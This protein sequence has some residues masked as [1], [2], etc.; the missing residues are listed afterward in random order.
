MTFS[1]S[2]LSR[3]LSLFPGR[4]AERDPRFQ[5]VLEQLP[6]AAFFVAPR[7]G[8]F[9]A[10]NGKA[11]ALT[12]WTRD[13]LMR[14]SLAEIIVAPPSE[15]ALEQFYTLE[16]GNVRHLSAIPLRTRSG[17]L[18]L[19]DLRLSALDDPE[20]GETLVLVLATPVEERLAHQKSKAQQERVLETMDQL[21]T[22]FAAPTEGSLELVVQLI[23]EMLSADAAGLYRVRSNTPGLHLG[24]SDGVPP[25][26]PPTIAPDQSA[27]LT[28]PLT[29]SS[30]QRTEAFLYQSARLA[31]WSQF[32]A[33]PIG[34]APFVIGS[35]FVAYRASN[36]ASA[37]TPALLAVAARHVHHLIIQITRE[38]NHLNAQELALRL[39]SRLAAINA[40]IEEGVVLIN[41]AGMIDEFNPAAARMFGYRS[42]EVTG[43]PCDEVLVAEGQLTEAIRRRRRDSSLG[44]FEGVLH[45]RGGEAFPASIRLQPLSIPGGGCVLTLRDLSEARA[46]EVRQEHLD[47]MAY[48]GQATQ[49]F[50]HEVRGPLNNIAMGVQ[51]LATRL[52]AE[53]TVQSALSKIQ[54]EC[55]RLSALMNDMLAWA[56]PVDPKLEPIDL[57]PALKRLLNRWSAKIAQ[58]NVRLNFNA[59]EDCPSVLADPRLIEQVFVNL[60]DNALQ[61]MPAGGHLSLSLRPVSRG[62]QGNFIEAR[63]V[64][65]GPGIPEE[66]RRRIFDPYFTTK[67]DG[68]G[69]GLA[70]CKR[71]VTI[72]R[73]VITIESFPGTGT[74][75]TV[76]L[77]AHQDVR[78]DE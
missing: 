16:A 14:Q 44:E 18:A 1:S 34:D 19:A 65:S 13:E 59:V 40:Q 3:V 70:I 37:Q 24:Y 8:T 31:G 77:P 20:R 12:E 29:W 42:E 43:L 2:S 52:P 51:Y 23:R 74:I 53:D 46:S 55:N 5:H 41:D 63:V 27:Y 60:I 58:R 69:L 21:L 78:R 71:L 38:A 28:S 11:A 54:A 67:P 50:A 36:P 30:G 57:A 68:T 62:A 15:A 33:Y 49:S 9:L 26:F 35:L 76:T 22:L 7:T 39:S 75:F 10:I 56:K 4:D 47:Q 61:A 6:A 32:I 73:G 45:R 25:G 66:I 72:H 17:R 48:M 64:D